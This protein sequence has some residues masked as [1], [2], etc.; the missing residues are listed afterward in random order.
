MDDLAERIRF[1]AGR[2]RP[3]ADERHE[4]RWPAELG[5]VVVHVHVIANGNVVT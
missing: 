1:L 3:A 4:H 2:L 5:S